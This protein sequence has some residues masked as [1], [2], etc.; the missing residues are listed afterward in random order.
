MNASMDFEIFYNWNNSLRTNDKIQYRA[1]KEKIKPMLK[2]AYKESEI[3]ELLL[4]EGYKFNLIKEALKTPNESLD[5]TID[6]SIDSANGV[7]KKYA[8]I[9]Y[10]LEK[11]LSKVGPSKFVKLITQGEN[12]LIKISAKEINVFQ[13]LA[14]LAFENPQYI[15]TLHSYMKPSIV[16]ELGEII[17]KARSIVKDC[18][19]A[20][21]QTGYSISHGNKVIEAS[22]KPVNST[23]EK[24][25]NSNYQM[26]GFPDEYV[27]IAFEEESPISKLKKDLG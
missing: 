4:A 11:T 25:V 9:S 17:C 23:S 22:I 20:K 27:I 15:D 19:V 3:E 18:K 24:F 26:F 14:N 6:E 1:I 2:K 21:T 5:I 7:P 12:P 10:K 16:S 8:D 13:K